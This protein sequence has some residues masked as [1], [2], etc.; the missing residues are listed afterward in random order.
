MRGRQGVIAA[1]GLGSNLGDRYAHLARAVD[2]LAR[3]P[4]SRLLR[5][6][7]WIQTEALARP[8]GGDAGGPYLNG[9]ALLETTLGPRQLLDALMA[10]ERAAGREREPRQKWAPRTLDLDLL[11]YGEQIIDEPWLRVPHPR[12]HERAFVLAPLAEIAPGLIVPGRGRVSDL[13]AQLKQECP[14]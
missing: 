3:L 11:V 10:I 5:R 8:D 2:D 14:A 9:A 13:L 1:I 12:L 6:S 7:A 4:G